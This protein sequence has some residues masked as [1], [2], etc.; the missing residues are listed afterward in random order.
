M[1][2][3]LKEGFRK[4][5]NLSILNKHI[6]ARFCADFAHWETSHDSNGWHVVNNIKGVQ[7]LLKKTLFQAKVPEIIKDT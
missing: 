5:K 7:P 2:Y 4:K 6:H 3:E 1:F